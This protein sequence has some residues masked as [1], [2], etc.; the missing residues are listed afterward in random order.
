MPEDYGLVAISGL[1]VGVFILLATTGFAAGIVN[2]V[3]IS[4]DELDTVFW[5]SI[6]LGGLLYGFVFFIADVAGGFYNEEKLPDVIKVAGLMVVICASKIVPS[7]LALRALD[8]KLI[9]L[10][11]MFGAFVGIA[12][13]LSMAIMGYEY[14]SLIIG[15]I[16]AEL[17]MT[18]TYYIF[19]KYIPSFV[20]KIKTVFDLL[21]FG[22]TLLFASALKYVSGNIPTFLLS[23]YI[24]TIATGH[25]Q[26]AHT[27]G[28]LPSNKVGTLFSNLIFPAVSRIKSDKIMA[29][30][31]FL[32]MHTSLLFVTGPMFIGLALVAEPL[33][34]VILTPVWAPIIVPFQ[35]ICVIAIFQ[36]SSLFITRAIEGLGD[37]KVSLNYQILSIVICGACMWFGVNGWGLNG[38]L[39]GWLVSSPIV[40][41][42][43]LGKIAKKLDIRLI[44]ILKMYLPLSICLSLMCVSVFG[45]LRFTYSELS[46]IAQLILSSVTG[47]FV[48][49]MAACIFA[50]PYLNSVKRVVLRTFKKDIEPSV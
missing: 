45:L 44:E 33:I 13:T 26:M 49:S 30:N 15:T 18:M 48:F 22:L 46:Y 1:V 8:Y 42:Y 10:N 19:Y 14:W 16:V 37:A 6:I 5:M 4:K 20:F 43:L 40:Y 9:S 21:Y 7:A 39:T 36:M 38:M 50:R 25:Y 34:N 17:F 23:T 32:Q 3:T 47:I 2:R 35:V 11:E 27:F 12:V 29:K 31:T 24:G 41:I 28:S